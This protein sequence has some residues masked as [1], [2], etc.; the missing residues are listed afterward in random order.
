MRIEEFKNIV[1]VSNWQ[2]DLFLKHHNLDTDKY[3][4][5]VIENCINPIEFVP[6]KKDVCRIIYH[7]TPHR[8]LNI[9]LK[10]F[11][12]LVPFFNEK[13]DM[14]MYE[15]EFKTSKKRY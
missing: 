4:Y 3:N 8:G 9:L 10:V 2:K 6:K 15:E 14:K 1:F 7:S 5:K 13:V 12:S 11:H